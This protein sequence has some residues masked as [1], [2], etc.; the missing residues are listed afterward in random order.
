MPI[1]STQLFD[2]DLRTVKNEACDHFMPSGDD[3]MPDYFESEKRSLFPTNHVIPATSLLGRSRCAGPLRALC[4]NLPVLA[5][6]LF[7]LASAISTFA[8][9]YNWNQSVPAAYNLTNDW[10]PNGL[11]GPADTAA[12]GNSTTPNGSVLYNSAGFNFGLN[13]L[14]LGQVAGGVGMFN[15]SAGVLG[16]TNNSGTALGIGNVAGG[17][18]YFTN[19]GGSLLVQRNGTGETYYRDTFQLGPIAGGTGFFTLNSGT[20]TCLGGIEIGSGG[21][22]TITVNG[23]TLIDNGWFG[24]G[25]GGTGNG[26]GTF[27]LTAGTVYL[28]RNP[29]TDGGDN[30]ISFCQGGTNGTVNIS[31]GTLYCYLFRMHTGPGSGKTDWETINI[32]GG[33]IYIGSGGVFDGNGGGTHNTSINLSGGTFHTVDLMYNAGGTLGTNSVAPDGADWS[34]VST[35]PATLTTSPGPGTVTFAPEDGHT[36]TLNAVFSGAG[37][38]TVDGPG[39]LAMGAAHT[40]AGKT[41][42]NQG[43]LS[44]VGSGA[45]LNSPSITLAAGATL[46]G[47]AATNNS[48]LQSGQV[49]TNRS[50]TAIFTGSINTGPGTVSLLYTSGVPAFTVA[51]GALTL[52]TNTVFKINNTG[53]QFGA[54]SYKLISTSGGLVSGIGLPP[55][56]VTGGGVVGGQFVSL[57]VLSNELYLIVTNDQ[58]PAVARSV[59]FNVLP[60]ASW[61]IVITNLAALAGWSDPDGDPVSFSSAGPMSANGVSITS[62]ST[63]IY[64][65]GAIASDDYFSYNITDGKLNG[66]GVVYLNVSNPT[67]VIPYETNH[68]ISLN[69]NW[70][71]Y[72][73]HSSSYWNGSI[74]NISII[75]SSQPFQQTNFVESAGWTNIAVP[76]NW[77]MAGFSPATY[78]G[79]DNTSGLYRDWFQVPASWQGRQVYLNFDG[80]QT[81]AELW[82]NGQPATAN[83]GSWSI[84]NFHDSGWTGFQVNITPLVNFGTSNL[85]AVRV[86]KQSPA[87]DLDTGDYFT[88]GGIFRPVTLYSVPQTNFA[89]VQ[90]TTHLLPGN[91]AEVDV[92]TDVNQ[93]DVSTPVSMTLNGVETVTNAANG[94][95]VFTQI[96]NQ[97]SLWSA[98]FPNLY[99]LI[100]KIKDT[101]GLITETVS[102]RIGIREI[103]ISNAVVLL[104]GVPV[105]FAGVCNHDSWGTN[106]NALGSNNW[107]ADIL[108]MKAANINAIRTTHYNF[109]SGFFDLC[110]ELGMYVMDELPYCWVSSVN[111]PN[112]TPAFQQHAREVIRRDR[113][114]PS[115]MVWAIGN[116]NSAGSNLQI[117]ADLVKSLD[118]TRPRLVSTFPAANYN[119]ELSDRHYPSPATMSSDG[120]SATVYPW[121]YM[122]QPNTWDVRLAADA[123]MYDRWGIAQQRVWNVVMQYSTIVGTFP[124]EWS[125]RAVQDPNPDASYQTNGVQMLYYFPSTG[126]HVL[127]IK[128]MVDCFRD[129]RPSVYEAQNIYSPVQIG[130]NLT[131]ASGQVFFP[132]TNRYSFTDLSYLTM[133]WQLQRNGTILASGNAHPILPPGASGSAQIP[134]PT[135]AL[136][137]A[138]GLRVD[139]YHPDGRDI[140][141]HQFTLATVPTSQLSSNLPTGLPI[142]T[143]NLITRK[144]VS[145]PGLW[146]KVLHYP[147]SLTSVVTTPANATNLSQLQALSATVLGG[148]NGSQTLGTIQAGYTNNNFSYTLTWSGQT[149]EVEQ[150][151]WSLQM[152]ATN[153]H[154]SWDRASR[155][156][157]YSP[158]SINRTDGIAT[159]D[160]TNVDYSRITFPNAFDFNST[161]YDC[162]WAGLTTAAGSGLRVQFNPSQRFHCHAG[163]GT[164]GYV[165]YVNQQ[166]SVGNDFTT[167]VVPDLIMTLSSGNIVQGSFT[168]GS[169]ASVGVTSSNAISSINGIKEIFTTLG[170][171]KEFGITFSAVSNASYSIWSSSNLVN[172]AWAGAVSEISPGLYQVFDPASTNAPCQFYRISAP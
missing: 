11:P 164:N 22:G 127:K 117:T 5:T 33:N 8:A 138:D 141:A 75:D 123:G 61:Q 82:I 134:V 158:T 49:L 96:I 19:N 162:N 152:P 125:D 12:V 109:G 10:T 124:F 119:V 104:N 140:I 148:T 21:V 151:G 171:S 43:T 98:E 172:W 132:V 51:S 25:R 69:G 101:N 159:P 146:N 129:Q 68:V 55:V 113:N 136:A 45:L 77:E 112:M 4:Q 72:L 37:N 50:S 90:V 143:I 157:V 47:S 32:S 107:R 92:T 144:T 2:K 145:D 116:E 105:K 139:F 131:I 170:G 44:F 56:T 59:S 28:L 94:K 38:L 14:Q 27:N 66:S 63:Y 87:V 103:T 85:L 115:V 91:Q 160:S 7:L 67:A 89:D 18:G 86:V 64:Y 48:T 41:I 52:A 53:A 80:V 163:A 167:Q 97:P 126:V 17:V 122:E 135:N 150:L 40:Y 149:W 9:T 93:G 100:L 26:W 71:F 15:L 121:I 88:L 13:V 114:H 166:V 20:V 108:M 120:A 118:S 29:N 57:N 78:F 83:E 153:D 34:W 154:F 137:Y 73:E 31:G 128:G 39:T 156:T 54:G 35:L 16:L 99:D 79:P 169:M 74:P 110:D 95:A 133:N 142:P 106:G 147:A 6:A 36:I 62:D 76:S 1:E 102:N 111:D 23:G 165:L 161:K 42:V 3:F 58:P 24:L 168:V 30:G 70:R 130:T 155:W 46:D 81:S 65:N 84:D 60:G